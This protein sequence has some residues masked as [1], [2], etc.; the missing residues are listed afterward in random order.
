VSGSRPWKS[1]QTV[2][3]LSL[4]NTAAC[5]YYGRLYLLRLPYARQLALLHY[6]ACGVVPT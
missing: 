5:R 1:D 6:L 4:A 2:S 3:R